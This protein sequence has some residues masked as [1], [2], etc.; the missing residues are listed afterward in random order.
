MA[1]FFGLFS[2]KNKQDNVPKDAFF[3]SPDESKTYGDIDY[4]RTTKTVK[5]T[6]V[7][8]VGNP[9]GGEVV[10]QVSSEKMRKADGRD[11][12]RITPK[13]ATAT[14]FTSTSSSSDSST[15]SFTPTA[16]TKVDSSMDMFRQ[17]AKKI[18]K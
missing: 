12:K 17:M 18:K 16:N 10:S 13:T 8:T 2:K 5:R 4:M 9:Q 6:F 1:G 7:K 3:L 14:D 15:G 11:A